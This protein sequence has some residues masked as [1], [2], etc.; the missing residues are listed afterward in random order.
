[1]EESIPDIGSM[2]DE[3]LKRMMAQSPISRVDAISKPLL[4]GQGG[5]DPRVVKA[6]S[7]QIVT[8]MK[9]KKLPVT[10]INYPDEG[11]G[12]VRPENR[13]SFF[14]I[15]EGFLAKCLGGRVQ[16]IGGDFA[17]SSLQVLEGAAYVPGLAEAAPTVAASAPAAK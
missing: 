1:M 7:D 16:P 12:F 3:D 6:E 9:A 4:I 10:Y 8:A 14:G 11:H 5:N 15:T 13:L 17:G 2:S